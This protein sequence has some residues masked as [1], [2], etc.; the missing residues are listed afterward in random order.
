VNIEA[1]RAGQRADVLAAVDALRRIAR[2]AGPALEER[3]KWNAP[4]FAVG[5]EDRIT[6][7]VNPRGGVRAVLHRGAKARAD[8][9]RFDDPEGLA[10]WRSPDRGVLTFRDAAEIEERR[11]ALLDLFRRWL[12]ATG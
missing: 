12:A 8:R 5:D 1:W 11:P 3:I 4:S 7:G 10:A 9:F 2:L 6:L